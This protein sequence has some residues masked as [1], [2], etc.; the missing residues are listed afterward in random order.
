MLFRSQFGKYLVDQQLPLLIEVAECGGNKHA[1]DSL[2]IKRRID[3]TGCLRIVRHGS[4][5][6]GGRIG[7]LGLRILIAR[8]AVDLV[9]NFLGASACGGGFFSFAES[10]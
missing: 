4:S 3:P 5:L 7:D 9:F 6:L 10:F 2:L 8:L 1:N